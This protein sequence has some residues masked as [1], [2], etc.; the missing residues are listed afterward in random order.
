MTEGESEPTEAFLVML[1]SNGSDV[2][3]TSPSR[4][5][6]DRP[7]ERPRIYPQSISGDFN[8]SMQ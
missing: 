4:V 1:L 5:D 8:F 6:S 2:R 7:K 3:N